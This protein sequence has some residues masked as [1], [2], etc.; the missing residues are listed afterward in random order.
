MHAP[1]DVRTF[2]MFCVLKGVRGVVDFHITITKRFASSASMALMINIL[3]H[4]RSFEKK[5]RSYIV[6]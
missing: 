3:S 5:Y 4:K 2:N 1:T 6:F